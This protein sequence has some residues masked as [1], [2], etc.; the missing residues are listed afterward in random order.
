MITRFNIP[1]IWNKRL[2]F[3][4]FNSIEIIPL[5]LSIGNYFFDFL[6]FKD[7]SFIN[8]ICILISTFVLILPKK[9]LLFKI[10]KEYSNLGDSEVKYSESNS[11]ILLNY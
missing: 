1:L 4:V 2:S 9:A 10:L 8:F 3:K 5:V 7:H 6:V 11:H